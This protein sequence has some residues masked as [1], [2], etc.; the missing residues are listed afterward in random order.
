MISEGQ[1]LKKNPETTK[2]QFD[3]KHESFQK[4]IMEMYQKFQATNTAAGTGA[5]PDD[6]IEPTADQTPEGKVIDA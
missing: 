6:I 3:E 1:E 2:E 4:E 5:N